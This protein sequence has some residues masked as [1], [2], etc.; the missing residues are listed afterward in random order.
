MAFTVIYDACV[1]YPAPVRDLLLRI[2]LTGVVRARW[3]EEILDECFRN[4]LEK[5]P[6]LNQAALER[7]R[8]L[9]CESVPDCLV[10]GYE[11]LIDAVQ[12]PDPDDLHVLAV[13]IH[14]GAQAIVTFNL[15]DFPKHVLSRYGIEQKHPDDFVLETINL[16][17]VTIAK[18][19]DDQSGSL[20]TP[21]VSVGELLDTLRDLGLNQSVARLR[22]VLDSPGS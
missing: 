14:A 21:P 11:D 15:K 4:I 2:G 19:I 20:R 6:D 10:S 12:L 13:A 7:T 9:M 16:S 17:P 8:Q 18:V 22:E 5:R 3:S 1:L